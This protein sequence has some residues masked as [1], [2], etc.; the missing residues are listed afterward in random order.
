MALMATRPTR[1]ISAICAMPVT[2]VQKMIGAISIL[3]NLMKASPSGPILAAVSGAQTPS[4]MPSAMAISTQIQSWDHHGL[5]LRISA[6]AVAV[7][8]TLSSRH[9][10]GAAEV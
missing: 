9:S 2:T 6:G 10:S 7:A 4:A 3:I 5:L 8:V 1:A